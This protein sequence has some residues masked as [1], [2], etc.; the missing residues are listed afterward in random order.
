VNDQ[1]DSKAGGAPPV[2]ERAPRRGRQ[3]LGF[4]RLCAK[5]LSNW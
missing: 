3:Y 5:I 1:Q 4:W 2:E